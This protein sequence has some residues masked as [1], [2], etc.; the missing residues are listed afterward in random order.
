MNYLANL[1]TDRGGSALIYD[2]LNYSGTIV[3]R[4]LDYTSYERNL[5]SL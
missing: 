2:L 5:F 1:R 3:A 4:V